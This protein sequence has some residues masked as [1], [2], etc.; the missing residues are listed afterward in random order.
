MLMEKD[1]DL[2]RFLLLAH[3]YLAFTHCALFLGQIGA[4]RHHH[5]VRKNNVRLRMLPEF[6]RG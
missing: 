2:A 3:G 4:A 6:G 1:R 5:I